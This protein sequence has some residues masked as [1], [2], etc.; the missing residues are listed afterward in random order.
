M[1]EKPRVS[2]IIPAYLE[3]ER[4]IP[5]LKRIS[6]SVSLEFECLIVIDEPNDKTVEVVNNFQKDQPNFRY[7]PNIL[8]RGPANAIHTGF[9]VALADVVVVTMADGSDD[10][11]VID[12]MV[13]LVERGVVIASASRYMPGG[14]QVGATGIKPILSRFAGLSLKW[15]ARVGT[16]DATNSFKAYSVPFVLSVGIESECGF[17]LGLE[18]VS[19]ARRLRKPIAEIPTIWIERFS[20]DSNFKLMS[21]LPH[22][23]IWFIFAFGRNSNVESLKSSSKKL[24]KFKNKFLS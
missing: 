18:L 7:V 2:I 24:I 5:V 3:N 15:W 4:I 8:G 16:H 12:Q 23:V 22:Y 20:G 10:P 17:E 14:Q 11:Q 21:W 9:E 13:L 6:E 19:K 1:S